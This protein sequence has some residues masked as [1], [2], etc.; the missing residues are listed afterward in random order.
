MAI[1]GRSGTDGDVGVVAQNAQRAS[2]HGVMPEHGWAYRMRGKF[3][4]WFGDTGTAT[5]RM[6]I[7]EANPTPNAR[8]GYTNQFSVSASGS[9]AGEATEYIADLVSVIQLWSGT[10]LAL[11]VTTTGADLMH[12]MAAAADVSYAD[13]DFYNRSGLG[14]NVPT[15]PNGYTSH[16]NEGMMTIAVEYEPNTAP[17]EPTTGIAPTG[18]INSLTPTFTANFTDGNTDRGDMM[19]QIDIE[20]RPVGGALKWNTA[21]NA[22]PDEQDDNAMS[23]AYAGSALAAGTTYEWRVR[24]SDQFG[25]WGAWSDPWFTFTVNA[26]G[27]VL[28]PSTPTGKQETITPGPFQAVWDHAS[29]LSTNSAELRILQGGSVVRTFTKPGTYT[30]ADN[31]TIS[32]TWA[33]TGFASLSWGITNYSF[34]IRARDTGGLWSPWSTARTFTTNAS[35]TIPTGLS[36]AN[37]AATST[38]PLLTFSMSDSDD[39]TGTGLTAEV[40]I[41][42]NAGT[43]LFTRTATFHSATN[44]WRYQTTGTDLA[45]FATYKWD[46]RGLDGTLNSNYSSE[47]TFAYGAGPAFANVQIA[48]QAAEGAVLTTNT[49][50]VTFTL[51]GQT[52]LNYKVKVFSTPYNPADT[53]IYQSATIVSGTANHTIPSGFLHNN[54]T[55]ELV[56]DASNT[57]PLAG[58]TGPYTF[59]VDYPDVPAVTGFQAVAVSVPGDI[60]G[61]TTANLLSWIPTTYTGEG[62]FAYYLITR[63]PDAA[64]GASEIQLAEGEVKL[65]KITSQN[66]TTF[67]DYFPAT[68]VPY[69]YTLYVA[70]NQG[71]D[72][73]ESLPTTANAICHFDYTIIQSALNPTA[74]RVILRI[75]RTTKVTPKGDVAYLFPWGEREPTAIIAPID[76]DI[77]NAS[78]MVYTHAGQ[79]AEDVISTLRAMKASFEDVSYRDERQ[80]KAFGVMDF[81][82]D[83]AEMRRYTV[84]LN[85]TET[86]FREG[87]A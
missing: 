77:I 18:T 51:T 43:V 84:T 53:P 34:Q 40:R 17:N 8:L 24:F 71:T 45:S 66:Q 65:T 25:A 55:Y 60:I 62:E 81:S 49:P 58:S 28:Q 31:G 73:T 83:Y 23:R 68:D 42:N 9:F 67:I 78:Y 50:A 10:E 11:G 85:I 86:N 70:I 61:N 37:S 87:F 54:T 38:L 27:T 69:V 57:V 4:R 46:A 29:G 26:G 6:G 21:Y 52:L 3:A 16:S 56:I 33:E 48:G 39:T 35:P 41:K 59:S 79:S 15:S 72:V 64:F 30:I 20:L 19:N 80:Q 2:V 14:S 13:E 1:F 32:F 7:W 82:L 63:K 47:A 44:K 12:Q 5:P 36:P 76:Y 22:T 74:R 75:A